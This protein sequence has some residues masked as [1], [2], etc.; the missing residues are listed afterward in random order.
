MIAQDGKSQEPKDA[1]RVQYG[2]VFPGYFDVLQV[3]LKAGRDFNAFDQSQ[4]PAGGDHQRDPGEAALAGERIRS[5]ATS[6]S[7]ARPIRWAGGHGGRESPGDV[8]QNVEDRDVTLATGLQPPTIRT[9][10]SR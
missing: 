3:P 5:A 1:L 7:L 9:R 4:G 2:I 10:P 8:M 6:S